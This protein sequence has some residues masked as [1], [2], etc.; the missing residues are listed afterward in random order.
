MRLLVSASTHRDPALHDYSGC[1]AALVGKPEA[2]WETL[3]HKRRGSGR[4]LGSRTAFR[5]VPH[6]ARSAPFKAFGPLTE[7]N[8]CCYC[9]S[10]VGFTAGSPAGLAL[11]RCTECTNNAV[12]LCSLA[13]ALAKQH[14]LRSLEKNDQVKKQRM[15]LDVINIELQLLHCVVHRRPVGIADLRPSCYARLHRVPAGIEGHFLAE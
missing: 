11:E 8:T 6:W 7:G 1:Y 5:V 15:I 12:T 14:H 13:R 2:D 10:Q 4:L 3:R 9:R